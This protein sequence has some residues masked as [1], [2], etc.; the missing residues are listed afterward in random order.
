M[1]FD[2]E[3]AHSRNGVQIVELIT[4]NVCEGEMKWTS[5][6]EGKRYR[7]R[8]EDVAVAFQSENE[9]CTQ[10]QSLNS[11]T[12]NQFIQNEYHSYH[13]FTQSQEHDSLTHPRHTCQSEN[14]SLNHTRTRL[15]H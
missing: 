5:S 11:Q 12:K 10:S 8:L 4:L 15:A 14:D 9:G 13:S 6:K 3:I 1:S 7:L 2:C